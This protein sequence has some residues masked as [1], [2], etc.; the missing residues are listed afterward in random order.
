MSDLKKTLALT[1]A[2]DIQELFREIDP[3]IPSQRIQLI[4]EVMLREGEFSP[5]SAAR[6]VGIAKSSAHRHVMMCTTIGLPH[7]QTAGYGLIAMRE[8][9]QT[10]VGGRKLK[11][12]V[13]RLY[14]TDRGRRLMADIVRIMSRAN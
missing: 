5:T 8:E 2:R 10:G 11:T 6:R 9:P 1:K 4:L 13:W 3:L 12:F 7:I 14:L